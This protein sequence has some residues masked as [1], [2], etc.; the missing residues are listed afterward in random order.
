MPASS[1]Q[2]L[3]YVSFSP[4]TIP[5]LFISQSHLS[6]P[7]P[8]SYA[9]SLLQSRQLFLLPHQAASQHDLSEASATWLGFQASLAP[10][11]QKSNL[12]ERSIIV[13]AASTWLSLS[14][15]LSRA[16]PYQRISFPTPPLLVSLATISISTG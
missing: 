8:A 12:L 2:S 13:I 1:S 10:L 16:C 7:A 4:P 14:H 15:R 6:L 11:Q 5:L 9:R 3:L